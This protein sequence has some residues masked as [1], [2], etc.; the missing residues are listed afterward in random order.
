MMTKHD[1]DR[2]SRWYSTTKTH[3]YRQP[4]CVLAVRSMHQSLDNAGAKS[5]RLGYEENSAEG[6]SSTSEGTCEDGSTAFSEDIQ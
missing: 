5:R 3:L 1:C 4:I 2:E 6:W